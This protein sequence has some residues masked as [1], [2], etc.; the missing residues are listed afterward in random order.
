MSGARSI[1]AVIRL[2]S[3]LPKKFDIVFGALDNLEE[4]RRANGASDVGQ[5]LARHPDIDAHLR[6]VTNI[7]AAINKE[8]RTLFE[9]TGPSQQKLGMFEEVFSALNREYKNCF[10][11]IYQIDM[12]ESENRKDG[13][14]VPKTFSAQDTA[15]SRKI[16]RMAAEQIVQLFPIDQQMSAK[17][18]AEILI[19]ELV[20]GDKFENIHDSTIINRSAVRDA[21]NATQ[22]SLGKDF[23]EALS[24]V[25]AAV[26]ESKNVA[27]GA[28]FNSFS[29]ELKKPAPDKSMLRQC[30][31]GLTTLLPNVATIAKASS[32]I[33][34][35][36]L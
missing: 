5:L 10:S 17:A 6:E 13:I 36:I 7:H 26:E 24:V 12:N 2:V 22:L 30:W 3:D 31:D 1:V 21:L 23:A 32:T 16:L 28:I 35:L 11:A 15:Q 29:E 33:A 4:F 20:M 27:A 8:L 34:A 19:E 18:K 14:L 25:A 9:S